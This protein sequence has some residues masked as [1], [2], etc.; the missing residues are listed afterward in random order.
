MF[1]FYKILSDKHK[2]FF[3]LNLLLKKK[4]KIKQNKKRFFFLINYFKYKMGTD[5]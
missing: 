5:N 4:M 3:S 1:N 2:R